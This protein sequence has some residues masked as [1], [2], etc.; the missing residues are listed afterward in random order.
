MASI[1]EPLTLA[2][3]KYKSDKIIFV[4]VFQEEFEMH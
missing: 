3:G 4:L 2:K 1:G